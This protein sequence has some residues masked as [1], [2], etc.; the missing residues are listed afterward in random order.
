MKYVIETNGFYVKS[1][2]WDTKEIE[3]AKRF[4]SEK[5]ALDWIHNIGIFN[6][7]VKPIDESNNQK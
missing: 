4:E 7:V 2:K 3:K 1:E 5:K 6:C